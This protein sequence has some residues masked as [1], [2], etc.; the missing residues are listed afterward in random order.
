VLAAGILAVVDLALNE[1][2]LSFTRE[3]AYCRF[4]LVDGSGNPPWLLRS[5]VE[6]VAGLLRAGIPTLVY[7][8]AGMSRSPCIAAAAIMLLRGCPPAEALAVALRSG[9]SD[10]SPA[11]WLEV[12]AVLA[13]NPLARQPAARSV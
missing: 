13:D 5:A 8:G 12:Q 7:C 10:V 3:M 11:L 1:P 6:T 9:P 2:P 4:P